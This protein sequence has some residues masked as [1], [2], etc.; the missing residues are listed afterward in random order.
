M[1]KNRY[2]FLFTLLITTIGNV[3]QGQTSPDEIKFVRQGVKR[4]IFDEE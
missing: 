1:K 3:A 4:M 2:I